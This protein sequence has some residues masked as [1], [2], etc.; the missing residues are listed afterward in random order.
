MT[1]APLQRTA[2]AAPRPRS[3]RL[4]G[5]GCSNQ[6]GIGFLCPAPRG[7]IDL[8]WKS[9]H[10]NR[11]GDTLIF[12]IETGRRDRRV[13]QPVVRDVV[14][15][16]ISRESF[17]FSVKYTCDELIAARVVIK[18]PRRETDRRIRDSV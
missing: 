14:E 2:A 4:W 12:P 5:A 9:A 18:D 16:V 6:F 8:V 13:C 3:G 17:S 1:L 10:G 7:L 15:D 11:D